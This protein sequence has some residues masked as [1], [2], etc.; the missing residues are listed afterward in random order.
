M[1]AYER[2]RLNAKNSFEEEQLFIV[3]Y[4][5]GC[6]KEI[7]NLLDTEIKIV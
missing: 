1:A 2:L 5:Q 4:L 7:K 3:R 6:H